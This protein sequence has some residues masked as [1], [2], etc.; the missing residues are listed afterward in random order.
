M[1]K[2]KVYSTWFL[3]PAMVIFIV[4]FIIPIVISLFFSLTVW[5][6]SGF[7]FCGLDNFKLFFSEAS[8]NKS[9]INTLIYAAGT[10]GLKVVLAFFI[11]IFLTSNIKTKNFIRSIVFFR[12]W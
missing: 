1:D 10:S 7:T 2:R 6:F 11:A 5:D 3:I 9:I 4:F 12:I 8:L